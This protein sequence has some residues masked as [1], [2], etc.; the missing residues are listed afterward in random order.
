VFL[1][2][3]YTVF[4]GILLAT[5]VGVGIQA[6]YPPPKQPNPVIQPTPVNE[7]SA[8]AVIKQNE[9]NTQQWSD[10]QAKSQNYN[11]DVS[12]ITTV[13]AILLLVVSVTMLQKIAL[14]ADGAL[15]G[16]L[17]TELYSTFRGFMSGDDKVRFLVVIIGL[18]VALFLG[19]TKFVN[20]EG[21]RK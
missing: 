10:Y 9:K 16:G 3:V 11:K 6:F 7:S 18:A 21:K 17:L 12:I 15:L 5:T 2:W 14:I 19:Y 1:K 13:A 4:I 20:E 8:S